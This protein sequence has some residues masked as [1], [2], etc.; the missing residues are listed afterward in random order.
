MLTPKTHTLLLFGELIL[1]NKNKFGETVL[2][3]EEKSGV[4]R[5]N[6][7]QLPNKFE[8]NI[9]KSELKFKVDHH[10]SKIE[11][12]I[13]DLNKS[14]KKIIAFK[15]NVFLNIKS[16]HRAARTV[17]GFEVAEIL[18]ID[19]ENDVAE[20]LRD[21]FEKSRAKSTDLPILEYLRYKS[22][23]TSSNRISFNGI[24]YW[25]CFI[26]DEYLNLGNMGLSR[27][28]NTSNN[29]LYGSGASGKTLIEVCKKSNDVLSIYNLSLIF[30]KF[31]RPVRGL[32]WR[33]EYSYGERVGYYISHNGDIVHFASTDK[34][35]TSS[36]Q[37]DVSHYKET[38]VIRL[39]DRLTDEMI[40]F[41]KNPVSGHY[42][43]LVLF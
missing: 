2:L 35:G 16:R 12:T 17:D 20:L 42:K 41:L 43:P 24:E 15:I 33:G 7:H 3:V 38:I 22:G 30:D 26:E 28:D 9:I 37:S 18:S 14:P 23:H 31:Y 6:W 29:Y 39:G 10:E 8:I 21:I 11:K 1:I 27:I 32:G 40:E 5:T 36:R 25:M 4:I 13:S 34:A 19:L